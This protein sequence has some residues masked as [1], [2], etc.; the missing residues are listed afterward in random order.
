MSE[1]WTYDAIKWVRMQAMYKGRRNILRDGRGWPHPIADVGYA[2]HDLDDTDYFYSL[3][4]I[5]Q[6]MTNIIYFI[7]AAG[8]MSEQ[9]VKIITEEINAILSKTP[10]DELLTDIPADEARELRID[11]EILGFIPPDITK[12][13]WG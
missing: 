1:R 6:L 10:L 11:L 9:G 3:P 7:L 8:Q 13:Q 2:F 12:P 4:D 5:H